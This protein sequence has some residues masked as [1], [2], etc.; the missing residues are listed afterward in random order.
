MSCRDYILVKKH[1]VWDS[2]KKMNDYLQRK[3][4]NT[5]QNTI[6]ID[7]DDEEITQKMF[8]IKIQHLDMPMIQN[9]SILSMFTI[10]RIQVIE[11]IKNRYQPAFC[12][13]C[14]TPY[15]EILNQ[16]ACSV[17]DT[18]TGINESID[19]E[20]VV[21][22]PNDLMESDFLYENNLKNIPLE[23]DTDYHTF[24][25]SNTDKHDNFLYK[26]Y[27]QYNG[28]FYLENIEENTPIKKKWEIPHDKFGLSRIKIYHPNWEWKNKVV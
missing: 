1:N 18:V 24:L 10:P 20:D 7:E 16:I 12:W 23:I 4:I 9:N 14:S 27:N 2:N 11:Y 19:F 15:G 5:I 25:N 22:I 21:N 28:V 17:C 26:D 13:Y 8:G 6:I 3:R